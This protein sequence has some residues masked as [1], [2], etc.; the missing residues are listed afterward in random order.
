MNLLLVALGGAIGSAAR[1]LL[2]LI[3]RALMPHSV[4]PWGTLVAN[5]LGGFLMGVLMGFV[6]SEGRLVD[7]TERLR[8]LLGVGV[9]GGFTTFSSFS[10]EAVSMLERRAYMDA[11]LYVGISVIGAIGAV[12]LG[13]FLMR[14]LMA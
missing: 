7:G 8:L 10:I 1:Y 3:V 5:S 11:A 12:W 9:L 14:R 2:S 6:W 13:L 4:W